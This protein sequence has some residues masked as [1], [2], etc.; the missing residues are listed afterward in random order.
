[1]I[2]YNPLDCLIIT[3]VSASISTSPA[4]T[5]VTISCVPIGK[6]TLAFAGTVTVSP[7]AEFISIAL[8]A[9]AKTNT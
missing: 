2:L 4:P 1:V 3:P 9:S 8:P 7:V 5:L 6:A